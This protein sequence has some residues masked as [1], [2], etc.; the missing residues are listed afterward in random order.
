MEFT[1]FGALP[2]YRQIEWYKRE[3]SAFFHFGINTFTSREWGEGTDSP[4]L[5]NPQKLDCRQWVKAIKEAGFTTAIITAKHHDGFC[6]WPSKYTNYSVKSSPYKNGEGDIV[7][8][9]TDACREYGI[10][11]GIYLSP[12]DR[13][14]KSYG[15]DS[16]N[17]FYVNQLT[18][19]FTNYGKIYEC[20]WDGA[21][22]TESDYDWARWAYTVRNLQPDCVIFGSLGATEFVESRWIGNES[23][24]A[25]KSC[26]ATINP[27]SLE[28]EIAKELNNG[29]FGGSRFIP[30]EADTSVRPGWFYHEEQDN[31]V[32]T[33]A[34]LLKYWF[35]SVGSNA[36]MLLNIPPSKD[37]LLMEN[38]IQS[39]IEANRM[40]KMTFA[41]NLIC[42]AK[43]TADTEVEGYCADKIIFDDDNLFYASTKQSCQ[44]NI[45][46]PKSITFDCFSISEKIEYGHRVTDFTIEICENGEWKT[47]FSGGCIGYKKA[48]YFDK[49]TADEIRVIINGAANPL[50]SHFGLYKL[51]EGCFELERKIREKVDIAKG[52]SAVINTSETEI[53]V[54]FGGIFPFN[55]IVFNGGGVWDYEI[56]A[57]NGTQYET[58]YVGSKPAP[59]QIVKLDDITGSYKM[60]VVATIGKFIE[61]SISVYQM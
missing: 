32:K 36:G 46:I 7:K 47:V 51:P 44:I 13:H 14:E 19:L 40:E 16:Y 29:C 24:S 20:W 21:G 50:I 6:L 38:D 42:G 17:D 25:A 60:R 39:I 15:T 34:E 49:V 53:E 33:P 9:F 27:S 1:G 58:V 22:S 23:G 28:K 5:F 11:A 52:A 10:K 30:A 3:K 35:N 61:P 56:Q 2:T 57:F 8:E 31:M 26:W 48:A 4:E 43:V 55:T 54:E 37:G 59:D 12:W 41:N 18:E 45:K